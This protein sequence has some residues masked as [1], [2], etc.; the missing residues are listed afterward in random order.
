MP[1]P[2]TWSPQV[3]RSEP[4]V[5][6]PEE[7]GVGSGPREQRRPGLPSATMS[8]A[9]LGAASQGGLFSFAPSRSWSCR[10][11]LY[12]QHAENVDSMAVWSPV[13]LRPQPPTPGLF[14]GT[15]CAASPPVRG[16]ALWPR[17]CPLLAAREHA[18]GASVPLGPRQPRSL[19]RVMRLQKPGRGPQ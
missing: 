8:A 18:C 19:R 1:G 7:R 13:L 10:P 3:R 11:D 5:W 14:H 16:E 15:S 4:L 17:R 2:G 9:H 6:P 12:P